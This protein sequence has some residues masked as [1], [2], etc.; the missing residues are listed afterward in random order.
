MSK[1]IKR[2]TEAQL[3][4]AQRHI[5]VPREPCD[6]CGGTTAQWEV[7]K[8]EYSDLI[9]NRICDCCVALQD[10]VKIN[11]KF[12]TKL[13]LADSNPEQMARHLSIYEYGYSVGWE[14]WSLEQLY[15]VLD[16]ATLKAHGE[17]AP[18][19]V[20][21]VGLED[22]RVWLMELNKLVNTPPGYSMFKFNPEFCDWEK[23]NIERGWSVGAYGNNPDSGCGW[24][25]LL[26]KKL[27]NRYKETICAG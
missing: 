9:L 4:T 18:T 16:E 17:T 11:R 19:V 13:G 20:H 12:Y 2:I 22:G 5:L 26:F 3:E 23:R 15:E 10:H 14:G 21:K 6:I 25:A 7:V 24:C 27:F 1:K 8:P